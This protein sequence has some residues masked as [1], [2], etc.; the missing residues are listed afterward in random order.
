MG[1]V[2]STTDVTVRGLQDALDAFAQRALLDAHFRSHPDARPDLGEI[3]L[4]MAELEADPLAQHPEL[5]R[6][7]AIDVAAMKDA[8]LPGEVLLYAAGLAAGLDVAVA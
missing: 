7:A 5:I 2:G 8:P 3:S 6:R 4:A 1:L